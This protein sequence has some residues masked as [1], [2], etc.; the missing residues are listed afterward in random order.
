MKKDEAHEFLS[1]E[2]SNCGSEHLTVRLSFYEGHWWCE[3][4]LKEMDQKSKG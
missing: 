2:C 4:C 1:E 3:E